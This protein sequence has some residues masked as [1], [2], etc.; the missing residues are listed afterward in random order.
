MM[1]KV[2]SN[3]TCDTLEVYIDYMIIKY[4]EQQEPTTHLESIFGEVGK[5]WMH[6]NPEK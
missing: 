2:V 1:N 3:H 4:N 5:Y 6:L